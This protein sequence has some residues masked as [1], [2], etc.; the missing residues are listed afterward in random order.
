M[1]YTTHD[2]FHLQVFSKLKDL[3]ADF[4]EKIIAIEGDVVEMELG[5]SDENKTRV[6][7]NTSVVIHLAQISNC[8]SHLK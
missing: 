6:V 8:D 4:Q 1:Y 2:W 7:E 3:N 5:M